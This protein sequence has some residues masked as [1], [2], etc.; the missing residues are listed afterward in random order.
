MIKKIKAFL[1]KLGPGIITGASDDDPSGIGTYSQTG[2]KFGYGL[3]WL[4]PI[5]CIFAIAIQEMCGRIGVVTGK[6][7]TG[8]MRENYPKGI[9]YSAI[10]LLFIANTVN[11]GADLGAMAAV[12]QLVFGLPFVFWILIM[13]ALT[14]TL[15]IFLDYRIYSKVLIILTFSLF[16]YFATAVVV[17]QDLGGILHG[18]FLPS[19]HFSKDLILNIVAF[20]GTTISPYLFFW[21]ADEEVEKEIV[22]YK[23][24]AIGSGRPGIS[25]LDINDMRIDTIIGM[26]FTALTA[27]MIVITTAGTLHKEGITSINTATD[28][29]QALRPLAGDFAYLLFAIG[30]IGTGLLGVPVLAGSSSYAISE[31]LGWKTGLGKKLKEAHG[32]YG[33]ITIATIIGL[34]INFIG[35]DPMKALYYAAA[36]NGLMAPPLMILILL[37]ANNKTVMGYYT[38]KWLSNT[39]SIIATAVMTAAGILL[40]FNL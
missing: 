5:S 30:I 9:S 14:L 12:A 33:V 38:N 7:L 37:I 3:L 24:K 21:Q 20:L 31:T 40:L 23:I 28:A 10:V 18:T 22:E 4:S 36:V 1:R 17:K 19:E 26:V 16:A 34:A 6:G 27:F 15:E 13:T 32:F 11:I 35:I 8:V 2:A 39:V 29:A 25:H